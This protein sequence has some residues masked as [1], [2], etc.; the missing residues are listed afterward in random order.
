MSQKPFCLRQESSAS[1]CWA[2]VVGLCQRDATHTQTITHTQRRKYK[3]SVWWGVIKESGVS[4]KQSQQHNNCIFSNNRMLS[5]T[6]KQSPGSHYKN[7]PSGLSVTP[8]YAHPLVSLS[9]ELGESDTQVKRFLIPTLNW[10]V[11]GRLTH[12]CDIFN[13]TTSSYSVIFLV[14][15]QQLTADKLNTWKLVTL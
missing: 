14:F 10:P 8:P 1:S 11:A 9:E 5:R 3:S 4:W 15:L 7:S 6:S 13:S 12:N 2:G